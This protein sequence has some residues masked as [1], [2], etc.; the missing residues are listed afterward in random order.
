MV[1]L[2]EP[3][4]LARSL[5]R[6]LTSIPGVAR[7]G[8]YLPGPGRDGLRLVTSRGFAMQERSEALV[9]SVDPSVHQ[10][11][12]GHGAVEFREP[13]DSRRRCAGRPCRARWLVPLVHQGQAVGVLE[14]GSSR[15][16]LLD[17]G[18]LAWLEHLGC[19]V[20]LMLQH[21]FDLRELRRLEIE[22][23][24]I[25]CSATDAI[26]LADGR[27][28]VTFWNWA[29]EN[30]FGYL[31]GEVLGRDLHRLLAPDEYFE[32]FVEGMRHFR[33][34]SEDLEIGTVVEM[35]ARRKDG[36][37]I[38]VEISVTAVD[39]EG[40]QL[41]VGIVR[42]ISERWRTEQELRASERRYRAIVE[43][44]T[45]LICRY[46]PDGTFTFVNDAYCRYF[47]MDRED[48]LGWPFSPEIPE[49]DQ[50][51]MEAQLASLDPD[52]PVAKV[53]HRVVLLDGEVRWQ[54]WTD[55]AVFDESGAVIEY[56]GV[57]RDITEQRLA[58]QGLRR[59]R[60]ELEQ[61]VE[62]RTAA[63]SRAN[64]QLVREVSERR[65]VERA[66]L[67]H[68]TQLRSMSSQLSLAEERERRRIATAVHDDIGQRLALC[69]MKLAA[70]SA[71]APDH[72]RT[73]GEIGEL[74]DDAIHNTRTLTFEI[75]TPILYDLGLVAAVEWAC[76]LVE[77]QHG[78][79]FVLRAPSRP[80]ELDTDMRVLLF[81]AVRELLHNMVKHAQATSV[82]ID[83]QRRAGRIHLTVSDDGVGFPNPMPDVSSGAGFGLF[84]IRERVTAQGGSFRIDSRPGG[85]ARIHQSVPSGAAPGPGEL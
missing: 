8:L 4:E 13:E 48:L 75:S 40:G 70:V 25:T 35:I 34:T 49:E 19:L 10:A 29:A 56:Q 41:V 21:M 61:R 60:E 74:L 15:P 28:R 30:L 84:A 64:E 5:G 33:A 7:F 79:R 20:G 12:L 52:Q 1:A 72:A 2:R 76:E 17:S 57:G 42:D 55:R 18:D 39:G 82:W 54:Q 23:H 9:G 83:I 44:Q 14:L 6:T 68:H 85:G 31:Q 59:A 51:R 78:I 11:M 45:E 3:V 47:G 24:S 26:I 22:L 80:L 27:G 73:L 36:V 69:R 16:A 32:S 63:L 37:E 77:Q 62:E 43:D 66:L 38:P 65:R 50:E 71:Q 81:R 46:E 53:E 67:R 58:E